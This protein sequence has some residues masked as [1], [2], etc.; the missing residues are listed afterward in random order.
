MRCPAESS[1]PGAGARRPPPPSPPPQGRAQRC[2]E[3]GGWSLLRSFP[4]P[5]PE[6]PEEPRRR[7]AFKEP[8]GRRERGAALNGVPRG[9]SRLC[10]AS[11]RA[12]RPAP[13]PPRLSPPPATP[14]AAERRPGDCR[15]VGL[16]GRK[17]SGGRARRA[18]GGRVGGG[19]AGERAGGERPRAP[20]GQGRARGLCGGPEGFGGAER[21]RS[22]RPR[23]ESG[24]GA[25]P[26]GAGV[27]GRR[28]PAPGTGSARRGVSFPGGAGVWDRLEPA[29]PGKGPRAHWQAFLRLARTPA[30]CPCSRRPPRLAQV[31]SSVISR[32]CF[33]GFCWVRLGS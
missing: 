32:R 19:S 13:A 10:A 5:L 22:L 16:E 12:P 23:G 3:V 20:R 25:S 28:G 6:P 1:G 33:Y 4:V 31:I 15:G 26:P 29:A 18:P 7:S 21:T 11:P 24:A 9:P 8:A 2:G 27:A 30:G 17:V 14:A